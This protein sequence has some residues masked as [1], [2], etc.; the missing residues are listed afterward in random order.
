[1]NLLLAIPDAPNSIALHDPC[2]LPESNAPIAPGSFLSRG[3]FSSYGAKAFTIPSV[4]TSGG[5]ASF[6]E[7][8]SAVEN[9]IAIKESDLTT[10]IEPESELEA[11]RSLVRAELASEGRLLVGVVEAPTAGIFFVSTDAATG[12]PYGVTVALG[13]ELARSLRLG[14]EY[15]LFPNSGEC[16]DAVSNGSVA[17]GFMPVDDERRSE[18]DF[19]P[20]YYQLESTYLATSGSGIATLGDVDVAGVRVIGLA[21]TTTI[22]AAARTLTNT[23]PDAVRSVAEAVQR[24]MTGT[25]DAF[26]LSRDALAPL[27]A[28]IPGSRIVDGSFHRTNI[29]IAVSKERP[30]ALVYVTAFIESAK[31][32]GVVR[33][34]FDDAGLGREAVAPPI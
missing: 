10:G 22:R 18:V 9:G 15:R 32:S 30:A 29:A 7:H 23:R 24:L 14:V 17:V 33:R 3:C 31:A 16:T 34:I 25:A 6:N 12:Y 19:G 4:G 21:N 8:R 20:A 13:A 5:W 11:Q 1:M 28:S 27:L 2:C 26:A